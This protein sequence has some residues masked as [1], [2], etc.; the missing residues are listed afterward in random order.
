MDRGFAVSGQFAR[1]P[2]AVE[3]AGTPQE[4]TRLSPGGGFLN[5][6]DLKVKARSKHQTGQASAGDKDQTPDSQQIKRKKSGRGGLSH[7]DADELL[8]RNINARLI[9]IRTTQGARIVR[10][11]GNGSAIQIGI[12]ITAS[13]LADSGLYEALDCGLINRR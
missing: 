7:A 4:K 10:V 5:W 11:E 3:H 2:Q 13:G 12:Q 9:E 6:I 1:L 8:R